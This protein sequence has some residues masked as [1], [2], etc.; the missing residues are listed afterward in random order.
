MDYNITKPMPFAIKT[1]EDARRA[2]ELME[3]VLTPLNGKKLQ[4]RL[5]YSFTFR[6]GKM[7]C[8]GDNRA[9][10]ISEIYGQ[11]DFW[12]YRIYVSVHPKSGLGRVAA[13]MLSK[14]ES[15]DLDMYASSKDVLLELESSYNRAVKEITKQ[16]PKALAIGTYIDNSR[17]VTL[18]G[19]VNNSVIGDNSVINESGTP[20]WKNVLQ[21]LL[22][23]WIWWVLGAVGVVIIS[24]V[25]GL[26]K[27]KLG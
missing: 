19:N 11:T 2:L 3:K 8:S 9:D 15:W 10:F 5:L 16:P 12:L 27:L 6:V 1:S 25:A 7:D 14:Y 17:H 4:R 22:V 26:V 24:M 20:F 13:L 21:S 18:G 23:N